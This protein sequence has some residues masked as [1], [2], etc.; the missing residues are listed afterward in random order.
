ME[1]WKNLTLEGCKFAHLTHILQ[2]LYL[3]NVGLLR[4]GLDCSRAS[5]MRPLTNGGNDWERVSMHRV[6][7]LNNL[8]NI[9]SIY[10]ATQHNRF[11]SEPPNRLFSE[12]PTFFEE[13]NVWLFSEP[14]TFF[15]ESNVLWNLW[16]TL[17]FAILRNVFSGEVGKLTIH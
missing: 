5:W 4:R 14:P 13:S 16:T 8:C 11:F 6:V 9:A 2:L 7:T 17:F 3:G 15:E 1:S 10:F 12:P